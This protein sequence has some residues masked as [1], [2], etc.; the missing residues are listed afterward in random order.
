MAEAWI[1]DQWLYST[2]A[3][4]ATL[5][6]LVGGTAS[7]RIYA[8]VAPP[9]VATP[10]IVFRHLAQTDVRGVGT[11]TIMTDAVYVVEGV[12]PTDTYGGALAQIADR[13]QTLLH[14][15]AGAAGTGRVVACVREAPF[16]LTESRDGKTWRRLGGTYRLYPQE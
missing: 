7:P 10:F 6:N 4:D 5:A 2:L 3:G 1:A 8:D 9:T 12:A 15:A 13:I 16:R 11:A 14:G